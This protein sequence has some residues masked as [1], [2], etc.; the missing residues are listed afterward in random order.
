MSNNSPIRIAQSVAHSA[1]IAVDELYKGLAQDGMALVIFFCSTYYDLDETARNII[2]RFGKTLVLGCTTAGEI[3]PLGMANYSLA[4]IS[5]SASVCQANA[6]LLTDLQNSANAERITGFARQQFDQFLEQSPYASSS[7]SFGFLLIDGLS[8][9]EEPVASAIQVVLGNIPLVGGSAGDDLKYT[10]TY[11]YFNGQFH[12][13]SAV[14][15]MLNTNLPFRIFRTQ[16][17]LSS[18]KWMVVTAADVAKRTIYELNGWPAAQEYARLAG[19]SVEKLTPDI[20]AN[21]PTVVRIDGND[22]VRSIQRVNADG[23]LTFYCAIEEGLVLRIAQGVDLLDNLN[24]AFDQTRRN[25]GQPAATLVCDCILRKLE[26]I[27]NHNTE[28]VNVTLKANHAIGF[29]TYGEQFRGIHINQTF[30]AIAIG[31]VS[32]DG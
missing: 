22:Y 25:I 12:R 30:A 32:K 24:A 19:F 21:Y 28:A 13:D 14:L 5:F 4:G 26:V 20:F 8:L 18:D 16:H 11:V 6:G 23:S 15:L 3:G 7:D 2:E 31:E 10:G 29:N 17:F 9:R 1:E 27:N